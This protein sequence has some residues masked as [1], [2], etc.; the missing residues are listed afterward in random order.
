MNL[1]LN[2]SEAI[3]ADRR[4]SVKLR[5]FAR[6]SSG[7]AGEVV[8]EVSDNGCGMTGDVLAH[9]FDPFFTTKA[10]GRGLGLAAIQTIVSEVHRG[11]LEVESEPGVGT[12]FRVRLPASQAA[13]TA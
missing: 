10:T 1:V 6:Q 11:E 2:A 9:I 3:S 8:L 5:C 12:T 13:R 4:G 7:G